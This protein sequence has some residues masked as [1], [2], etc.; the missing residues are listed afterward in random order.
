[1][2]PL[3]DA[4]NYTRRPL[5]GTSLT[6]VE[7]PPGYLSV[8]KQ[9]GG[10]GMSPLLSLAQESSATLTLQAENIPEDAPIIVKDVPSGV[11]ISSRSRENN[12]IALTLEADG[13][14]PL[15]TFEISAE[16]RVG[17][18]GSTPKPSI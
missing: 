7:S 6:I 12:Q 8:S 9:H 5:P 1:M 14:T 15:G 13:E 3:L 18:A 17:N 16:A 11:T 4:W 10:D 2:G